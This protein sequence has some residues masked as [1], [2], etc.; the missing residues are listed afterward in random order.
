MHFVSSADLTRLGATI[1][2]R[3]DPPL[4]TDAESARTPLLLTYDERCARMRLAAPAGYVDEAAIE[5]RAR[6]ELDCIKQRCQALRDR[7]V[8]E[9]PEGTCYHNC[10]CTHCWGD[11]CAHCGSPLNSGIVSG[12]RQRMLRVNVVL[13]D[14]TVAAGVDLCREARAH[15]AAG[16]PCPPP[17]SVAALVVHKCNGRSIVVRPPSVAIVI[18]PPAVPRY[19]TRDDAGGLL[20]LVM[21]RVQR[22]EDERPSLA[23]LEHRVHAAQRRA[24]HR[25]KRA[26][27]ATTI[28]DGGPSPPM[29]AL[30]LR[31]FAVEPLGARDGIA[32]PPPPPL[33]Y[34]V[35]RAL[36]RRRLVSVWRN[37]CGDEH[38]YARVPDDAECDELMMRAGT[39]L[40]LA[41]DCEPSVAVPN[42]LRAH[43]CAEQRIHHRRQRQRAREQRKLPRRRRIQA[44]ADLWQQVALGV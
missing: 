14:A 24:W 34:D 9:L 37:E 35:C 2:P 17:P 12:R 41:V 27:D 25:A 42:A 7:C 39:A 1:P 22:L 43:Y 44:P 29:R 31:D 8:G 28:K 6:H 18:D 33:P 40:V 19:K 3:T 26:H 36:K 11:V 20:A 38:L 32:C 16:D 4:L 23:L 13:H 21:A 10:R 15:E 5:R 30:A